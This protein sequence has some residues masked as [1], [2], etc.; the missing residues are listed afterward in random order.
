[1]NTVV[2]AQQKEREEAI[3][4]AALDQPAPERAGH[5]RKACGTDRSLEK[6]ILSL[7]S[8]EDEAADFLEKPA[9]AI[10]LAQV[11][12][13]PASAATVQMAD[14]DEKPGDRIGRYRLLQK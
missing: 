7:L 10:Q 11:A 5:V 14:L 2:I 1:M 12:S 6:R 3:F 9:S 13:A 8:A 4:Q